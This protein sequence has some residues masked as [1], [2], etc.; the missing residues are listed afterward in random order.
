MRDKDMT[1][2]KLRTQPSSLIMLFAV[3]AFAICALF[4][5]RA[6]YVYTFHRS[7]RPSKR[8]PSATCKISIFLGSG[9]HTTE[10]LQLLAGLNR[11]RYTPRQY[12]VSAGDSL[13]IKRALAFEGSTDVHVTEIPRARRVHQPL[14]TVPPSFIISLLHTVRLA[15]S[16]NALGDFLIMNGPGTCVVLCAGVWVAR[17]LGIRTPRMVY[18]ESFARVQSLSLSGKILARFVDRFV[19]QWPEL[20][21]KVPG[22]DY[23]GWLV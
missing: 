11:K 12:I 19:V 10:A 13:S 20:Q 4:V 23:R 18:I 1:R 22:A 8:Q 15:L 7:R 3:A 16:G 6:A 14:Y 5:I 2:F 17:M 9:G 21:A